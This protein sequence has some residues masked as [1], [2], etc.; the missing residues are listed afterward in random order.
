MSHLD[1]ELEGLERQAES[2]QSQLQSLEHELG[3][4]PHPNW[5]QQSAIFGVI[6]KKMG[7]LREQMGRSAGLEH[8]CC[9]PNQAF[10]NP[11][12]IA[13]LLR[14]RVLPDME[15]RQRAVAATALEMASS[16][17]S[18]VPSQFPAPSTPLTPAAQETHADM[19]VEDTAA[20]KAWAVQV[21]KRGH[22][23][24]ADH[25]KK[26][27]QFCEILESDFKAEAKRL[28]LL[29]SASQQRSQS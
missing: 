28:G 24:L 29:S 17:S 1:T 25:V 6:S 2:L 18:S 14:T 23:E 4:N 19:V 7:S 16:S 20:N 13:G 10:S 9:F 27:D 8:W 26:H 22:L 15:A 11:D 5:Q 3:T 21:A 12:M